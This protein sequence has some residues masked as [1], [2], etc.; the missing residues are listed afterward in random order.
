[1]SAL[2]LYDDAT[3]RN[4]EPFA[5]TRPVSELRAGTTL[6]RKRW[7]I[8]CDTRAT[9]FAGAQHLSHF[10][11]RGAP[12]S[13]A[14]DTTIPSGSIIANA[15]FVV[16]LDARL[17]TNDSAWQH[18]GV[19]CAMR[20][21]HDIH[22]SRLLDGSL[23]FDQVASDGPA[24][25]IG[26]RWL[27]AV[28]DL[29]ATLSDQLHEDIAATSKDVSG[30]RNVADQRFIT[31]GAHRVIVHDDATVEPFV[32]LDATAGPICIQRGAVISAFTRIVGP[33]FI[34]PDTT[35][36]G[37]RVANCSIGEMCKI[38]GE[39]SSSIVLGYCN[40]GHTGFVGHSYLGRWVNLG[41]GTTTSNLKNT[42]G[43]V[44]LWSPSGMVD[45]G[46]Q[47]LGTLFGDH[48]KTGIGTML[49]TGTV[50]G[51]GA[52]IYGSSAHPKY[53]RPFAWGDGEPY[54]QFREEKFLE[55]AARVMQRRGVELD[56][57]QRRHLACAHSRATRP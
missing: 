39:I 3:A 9:A 6:I 10:S 4:F 20:L 21:S 15:R 22:T 46:Q 50:L 28:W 52:N 49:T 45:T 13:V 56:E 42:Y 25:A 55:V 35:I 32:V 57:E 54:S 1:M 38:R 41:A 27:A 16:A 47:F 8:A 30:A 48:V 36:A 40:K 33:C 31:V 2:Y 7:E 29:V 43:T 24:A 44:Q 26:G 11:E 12:A 5:L 14:D 37:D 19:L 51:A 18:D 23:S 34:G 17:L 53:V